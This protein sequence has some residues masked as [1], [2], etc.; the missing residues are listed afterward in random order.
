MSPLD[1]SLA[2]LIARLDEDL[3]GAG[4][5]A[6]VTEARLRA[7]TLSD[8]G[9]QL[10]DHYVSQ[11]KRSGASWTEIG[12]AI[13]VS[14][15]AAQQRHAPGPFE[16]YTQRNRHS[17]VLAQ[18][19]ARTHKHDS[20]GTEHLLLGLLGEPRGVAYGV[21]AKTASERR[22]RDAIEEALPPA[23]EKA[24]RGHIAFRPESKEAIE[25]ARRASA[26]LG[27]D[28]VGTEHTLLGLLRTEESPAARILRDLGFT[29]DELRETIRTEIAERA[30]AGDER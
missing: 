5:L 23:G 10:I 13:G 8:L 7:Q 27:H 21:L 19:A 11:A 25:Q 9:D 15:Q 17:I 22:I 30:A 16:R 12:D 3:P 14:K 20:I 4:E 2:D 6:R 29:P 26:D 1:I 18:E 24:L 28:W